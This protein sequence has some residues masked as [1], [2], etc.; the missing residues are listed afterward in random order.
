M[1]SSLTCLIWYMKGNTLTFHD[2]K[3]LAAIGD[4]IGQAAF[5]AA[6]FM[7]YGI[8]WLLFLPFDLFLKIE[9][10]LKNL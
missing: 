7:A 6:F 1:F 3:S 10:F 9:R 8:F 4:T 5:D 2:K